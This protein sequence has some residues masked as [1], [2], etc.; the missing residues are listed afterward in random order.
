MAFE[1]DALYSF[2]VERI[3]AFDPTLDTSPGSQADT[4][5]IQ[6]TLARLGTDPYATPIRD[7]IFRRLRSEFPDLN[8][9][10]GDPLDEGMIKPSQAI[11]APYRRTIQALRNTQNTTD[12]RLL[13][14]EEADARMG[15]FF[16]TRDQGGFATGI[17]RLYYTQPRSDTVTP[18]NRIFSGG[19]LGFF[20]VEIQSITSDSMLTYQ[21]GS[22]HYFDVVVRAEGEGEEYNLPAGSLSGIEGKPEVVAVANKLDFDGGLP[23]ETNEELFAKAQRQLG[24]KSF[25]TARGIRGRI[26][27]LFDGVQS[28]AV[29]GYND[30]EMNRDVLTATAPAVY[31]VGTF[32]SSSA[33]RIL[34]CSGGVGGSFLDDSSNT[35]L[36][37]SGVAP[38][39][40]VRYADTVAGVIREYT[41][42][43]VL[44]SR[45]VRVTPAPPTTVGTFIFLSRSRGTIT[46]SDIPGGILVPQT[47]Q[48]TISVANN[49]VHI[50]GHMD[51]FVRAGRP[52][53]KSISVPGVRD[54][55]PL[56]FGIDLETFG[57]DAAEFVQVTGPISNRATTDAVYTGPGDATAELLIQVEDSGTTEVPWRPAITDVGRYIELLGPDY[58]MHQILALLGLEVVGGV[59]CMRVQVAIFDQHTQ[60]NSVTVSDRASVFDLSFRI[61][62]SVGVG[63]RVRDRG[64]PQVDFNGSAGGAGASVGD[65]VVIESGADAGVYSIRRI[66]SSIGEDDTLILDRA[67]TGTVTPSGAGDGSGVRYRVDDEIQLDLVSPRI[68]KIP[69]NPVFP[70]GDLS[71]VAASSTVSVTSGGTTNFILAGVE[72][73]DTLEITSGNDV[74]QYE[75]LGVVAGQLQVD[76]PPASTASNLSFSIYKAYD[77][78]DLPL[79]RVKAV[80]L[81]DSS[82]QPTGIEVPY[83][84]V[85]DIRVQGSLGN[86]AQGSLIESF[87]GAVVS[88]SPLLTFEDARVDFVARGVTAGYRLEIFEGSNANEYEIAA[89]NV[90]SN[91][92]RISVRSVAEGG[93]AFLGVETALHYRVGLPSSGLARF[94]F[95]NPTSV[96]LDTGLLGGRLTYD[97]G[98]APLRFRFSE[99]AGR[100]VFPAA[101]TLDEDLPRDL[102]VARVLSLGGGA[103][104][105]I[106]EFTDVAAADVFEKEIVAGDVVEVFQQTPFRNSGGVSFETSGIYGT[107]SGLLT[108]I[109]SNRVRVLPSSGIDFTQMGDLAGQTLYINSGPDVGRYAISRVVDA[110]TLELDASLT[111]STTQVTGYERSTLRDGLLQ[112]DPPASGTVYLR[113]ITDF[114]QLGGVGDYIR[115]FEATDPA[116]EGIFQV[117]SVDTV[118]NRVELSGA[119]VP[120]GAHSFAWVRTAS[121][122]GTLSQSFAIYDAQPTR[123]QITQVGASAPEVVGLVYGT[124]PGGAPPLVTING[125]V[126]AFAGVARNDRL[127]VLRGPNAGVYPVFSATASSVT[128][129][130]AQPFSA[131]EV[132]VPLR[133]WAGLHGNLRM[134]RVRGYEGSTGR[135]EPGAGVPYTVIRPGQYRLSATEM[136]QQESSGLYYADVAIESMGPGDN[137]NLSDSSRLEALSGVRVDGFTYRVQNNN[138]TFSVY[139]RVSLVFD[140][141]FLAVGNTDL[142]ENQTEVGGRN[143]EIRYETSPAVAIINELLRGQERTVTADAIARHFLPT[144]VYL[145]LVYSGGSS[146]L[147]VGAEVESYI[148][149]LGPVDRLESSDVQRPAQRRGATYIRQPL[150]LVGVTH[151]IDRRLVVERSMDYLGGPRVPYNGTG[152]IST[153]FATLND[154][155]QVTQQ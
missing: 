71:T 137:R 79:V 67:L 20:P 60:T 130:T 147:L 141:R 16:V 37:A 56:H 44:T 10:P 76:P 101:S 26:N 18:S 34:D 61:V 127:E 87:S 107:A 133:V 117:A 122:S 128:V 82:N 58:S 116:L 33:T 57:A 23:S 4:E 118:N 143:L 95:L 21:E 129:Y 115:I 150:V 110:R 91:P 121:S 52:Q 144:F 12:P 9:Q 24:E 70:G 94:Y 43:E 75:V 36:V 39:D 49:Q 149:R 5:I 1:A 155:L 45:Q 15:N 14:E 132:S 109:G 113:D 27:E 30:I 146:E 7:M 139:E 126:N 59:R 93:L 104:E 42:E 22:R 151:D 51:V 97:S 90:G 28:I 138:L 92:N 41:V 154:G 69:L 135:V 100:R 40:L 124:I 131:A 19:G 86:R 48:G 64:N 77:G 47:P 120:S 114:G 55:E 80:E 105:T 88:G 17:A 84:D 13:T 89:V 73:G 111:T 145:D 85:I 153:F 29:V 102:R 35:D 112:E 134:V 50:G 46:I 106:L 152:R 68:P 81:L 53:E 96:E 2:L 38:G 136:E 142:P 125:P 83:G 140:R 148:N 119:P 63:S 74:G 6:P 31:G 3:L 66:L 123:V 25:V 99:V 98:A 11:V 78:V 65:S 103:F 72:V 108:T 62:D 8:L 54:G 32:S